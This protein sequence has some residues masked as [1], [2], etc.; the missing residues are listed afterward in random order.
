MKKEPYRVTCKKDE[1]GDYT[2]KDCDTFGQAMTTLRAWAE[3][4]KKAGK[5]TLTIERQ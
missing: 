5:I 2:Q 1:T 4:A 3:R